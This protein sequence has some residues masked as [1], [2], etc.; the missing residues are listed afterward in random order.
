MA[1]VEPTQ[2]R[3]LQD[4]GPEVLS[5][6]RLQ[7]EAA[8]LGH[9]GEDLPASVQARFRFRS[10]WLP[11]V[12]AALNP[13]YDFDTDGGHCFTGEEG[14]L[15]LLRH[16]TGVGP[17]LRMDHPLVTALPQAAVSQQPL[18][19]A[20]V[21][22]MKQHRT[23]GLPHAQKQRLE[24]GSSSSWFRAAGD[25]GIRGSNSVAAA[26]KKSETA[27]T[28]SALKSKLSKPK[29]ALPKPTLSTAKTG[30]TEEQRAREQ[31]R[32]RERAIA[33][34]KPVPYYRK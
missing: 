32:H 8:A 19:L 4:I 24:A 5:M 15:L 12:V 1:A 3:N 22:L 16:M 9:V 31:E 30:L 28:V 26:L 27:A 34:G 11:H 14:V 23:R 21:R 10:E 2:R 20:S 7:R 25:G 13:P 6:R 29:D 33:T 18:P 17:C